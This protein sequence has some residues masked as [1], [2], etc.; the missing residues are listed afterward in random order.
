MAQVKISLIFLAP[1]FAGHPAIFVPN[2]IGTD[3]F[4]SAPS[5]SV[6]G[7]SLQRR[8]GLVVRNL[9]N[10]GAAE[11]LSIM[12]VATTS[13]VGRRGTDPFW[14]SWLRP[15]GGLSLRGR[16]GWIERTDRSVGG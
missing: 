13:G 2:T 1:E 5:R 6:G 15:V 16:M 11:S 14:L 7:L 10:I 9:R 8:M 12:R 4:R 3:P